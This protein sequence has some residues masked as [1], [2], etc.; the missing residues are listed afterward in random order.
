MVHRGAEPLGYWDEP[1]LRGLCA[2]G[3]TPSATG[4]NPACAGFVRWMLGF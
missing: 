1:R 3:L 2:V 4:T